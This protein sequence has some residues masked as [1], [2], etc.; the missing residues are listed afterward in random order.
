MSVEDSFVVNLVRLIG[1]RFLGLQDGFSVERTLINSYVIRF[2]AH[3]PSLVDWPH[4][5][6]GQVVSVERRQIEEVVMRVFGYGDFY[7]RVGY[8]KSQNKLIWY[9]T[10]KELA[11]IRWL[12]A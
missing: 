5:W 2:E 12:L 10:D 8:L 9:T 7:I 3:D 6:D 1:F 11:M 4:D